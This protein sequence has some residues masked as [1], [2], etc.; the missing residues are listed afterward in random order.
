[1]DMA[2]KGTKSLLGT[3]SKVYK[4]STTTAFQPRLATNNGY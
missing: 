2:Q 1:M 3:T 4:N